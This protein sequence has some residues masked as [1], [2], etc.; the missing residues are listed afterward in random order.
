M[1]N[2]LFR[3][4]LFNLISYMIT[5]A[6]GLHDE[7]P[8]YG[9]FRMLDSTG[10]LLAIMETQGLLDPFLAD[11]KESV[12]EEREGNMEPEREVERLDEM[13]MKIAAELLRRLE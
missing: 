9:T 2:E 8:D 5:S 12:D 6:R 7:P 4:E 10:R 1:D 11:L 3:E 13:V